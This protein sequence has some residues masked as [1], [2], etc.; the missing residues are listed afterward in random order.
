MTG[1]TYMFNILNKQWTKLQGKSRFLPSKMNFMFAF[2]PA[3]FFVF[4]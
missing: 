4:S 3:H 2:W 1:E